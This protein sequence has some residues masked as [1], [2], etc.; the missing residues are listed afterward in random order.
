VAA[1]IG[2]ILE[3]L[4]TIL[5][6]YISGV[7]VKEIARYI[8]KLIGAASVAAKAPKGELDVDC[9]SSPFMLQ[10]RGSKRLHDI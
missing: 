3:H 4:F 9:S 2:F 6:L 1:V 7:G 8:I 5:A 10:G